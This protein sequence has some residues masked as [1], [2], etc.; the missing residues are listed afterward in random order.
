M[1][2]FFHVDRHK[3]LQEGQEVALNERGLSHLGM[4]Y[5]DAIQ[6]KPFESMSDAEQREHLL[7]KIRQEPKFSAYTSRMHAFFGANTIEDAKRFAD[8]IEPK[9]TEPVP[10]FE[11]FASVF[12]TLDMNWL[13]YATDHEQRLRNL[14]EYWYAA[15]SNHNPQV[16]SR[17]PPH[18]EV[19]MALPVTVGKIVDWV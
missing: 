13:D 12:W 1:H 10:I 16:G 5:W 4:V 15:I 8:K 19:L 14:R 17:R 9:P 7:E 6:S 18:L 11:V 2:R 3:Q